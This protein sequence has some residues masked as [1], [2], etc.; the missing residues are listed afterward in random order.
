[1]SMHSNDS[2]NAHDMINR[3]IIGERQNIVKEGFDELRG[4]NLGECAISSLIGQ[5][6]VCVAISL[7]EDSF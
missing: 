7:L 5:G 6:V 2:L 4:L 1:M 3:R